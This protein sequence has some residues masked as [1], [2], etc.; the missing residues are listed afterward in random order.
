MISTK[1]FEYFLPHRGQMV[2][3]DSLVEADGE[4]SGRCFVELDRNKPYFKE[5]TFNNLAF[6]EFIAQSY[7][8]ILAHS[9]KNRPEE[10]LNK[11]FI[12]GHEKVKL[13]KGLFNHGK[14]LYIDIEVQNFIGPFRCVKGKVLSQDLSEIFCEGIVKL[15]SDS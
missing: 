4:K 2:W 3:I 13:Y 9:Y 14:K 12:V 8:F 5:G 1:E 15:F 7:G 11:A 6:V 10:G